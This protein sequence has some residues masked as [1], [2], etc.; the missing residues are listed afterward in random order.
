MY[1][2]IYIH[3]CTLT[4]YLFFSSVIMKVAGSV[5]SNVL[6]FFPADLGGAFPPSTRKFRGR[7]EE[8]SVLL[9][10]LSFVSNDSALEI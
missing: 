3:I 1:I 5:Y 2:Y 8:K 10:E 6:A 4:Y 7:E 9:V